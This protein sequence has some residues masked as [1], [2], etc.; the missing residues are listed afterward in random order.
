MNY[1]RNHRH[2]KLDYLAEHAIAFDE[3]WC[4][5]LIDGVGQDCR[6]IIS[7]EGTGRPDLQE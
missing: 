7:D 5:Q 3:F 1:R 2:L 4:L 6:C